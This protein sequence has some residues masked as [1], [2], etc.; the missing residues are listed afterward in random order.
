MRLWKKRAPSR[1]LVRVGSA[2]RVR[3]R[4]NAFRAESEILRAELAP[5]L[6]RAGGEPPALTAAGVLVQHGQATYLRRLIQPWQIRSFGY[7]DLLGEIKYASQFYARAL[8]G[9]EL[10]AA[11]RK[12]DGSIERTENAEVK[13]AVE[14]IRDPGGGGRSGLLATFGRLM[15]LV[16]EALLF[17]SNNEKTGVEQWEMLS[18]DELRMLDGSYT[19]FMAPSLP[20]M[21]FRP[22]PDG[23]YVPVA[24]KEQ[25]DNQEAV[26]YR[27]WRK[28]PR[29]SSLPDATMEGV[30]DLC[31]ELV[32]LTAA[33][34]ARAR[35]RLANSGILFLD[36]RITTR[37]LAPTPDEDP[38][39][40]PFL[41]DLTESMTLPIVDEGSASS[42][43]P[44]VAR[45]KVPTGT[46]LAELIFHLQVID[47]LQVYPETGLREECI[48]RIAIGLDMPPEV[49]LGLAD[50]NHWTAW[51]LDESIWKAHIQPVA[52][53]LV[54]DLTS[55]YLIPYLRAEFGMQDADRYL[56]QYD[57]TS[58][59]NHPDR[60]KDANELYDRRAIGKKALRE[61]KGFDEKDEMPAEEL[62]E[63]IG[64]AINDGSLAV[65]GIPSLKTGGIEPTEGVI[66]QGD[67]AAT[68]GQPAK[69]G[70]EAEKG[71]PPSG[72]PSATEAVVG[73]LT[74]KVLGA[75]QVGLL[76][77]RE[78]AGARIRS[79]AQRD[80][81]ASREISGLAPREIAATLGSER[82]R[83]LVGG[84][85]EA[86]LV[87]GAR[88]LIVDAL[89]C[90]GIVDPDT[91]G[92]IADTVQRHAAR[93]LYQPGS[94]QL[95]ST[96]PSY[97]E[98]VLAVRR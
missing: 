40:D 64:V 19:R 39:E 15:F 12:E 61:A 6:E 65:Y 32:L 45:V 9:L 94:T 44:L 57:A 8:S 41:E 20:A 10:Y 28:H 93:T 59:I 76:R 87:A 17:V 67:Q 31:E 98:G 75:S 73:A 13:A 78:A 14:R 92:M 71:A 22:A 11:E 85:K 79:A 51:I 97:I 50:V 18:T 43:V 26:A 58:V 29:F 36:E 23:E 56:V 25:V 72:P 95:P 27:L 47:P 33:V 5:R 68:P 89:R 90:F 7:Y 2:N 21:Q 70:A 80:R 16:G 62:A 53:G 42:V 82:V 55:A 52:D 81:E 34:R 46:R 1:A 84:P 30:L 60:G 77:A 35:S 4:H 63:A 49:L 38:L 83:V 3:A 66:E 96:F 48:R 74:V 37:P 69:T 86:E 88:P 91:Q 24:T 54:E